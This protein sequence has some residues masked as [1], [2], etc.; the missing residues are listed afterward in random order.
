MPPPLPKPQL[1]KRAEEGGP[2]VP[3]LRMLLCAGMQLLTLDPTT[4]RRP[5]RKVLL[6][7]ISLSPPLLRQLTKIDCRSATG[8][9][10]L[11]L[12]CP[13]KIVLFPFFKGK[14]ESFYVSST[15]VSRLPSTDPLSPCPQ[16]NKCACLPPKVPL[17]SRSCTNNGGGEIA[18][19]KH[20]SPLERPRAAGS[21]KEE[22]EEEE[23]VTFNL[24]RK[25]FTA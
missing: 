13:W 15:L 25:P 9:I 16:A 12:D 4:F 10:N 6:S 18:L 24:G 11:S 1:R 17:R 3:F 19:R 5:R 8:M 21:E 23:E 22:E 2:I 20:W 7:R 14:E